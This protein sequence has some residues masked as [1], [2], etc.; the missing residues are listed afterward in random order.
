MINN[1]PCNISLKSKKNKYYKKGELV[2]ISWKKEKKWVFPWRWWPL[3]FM[4]IRLKIVQIHGR[5][6]RICVLVSSL[7]ILLW[8]FVLNKVCWSFFTCTCACVWNCF[9]F[10]FFA[11]DDLGVFLFLFWRWVLV[12]LSC[13]WVFYRGFLFNAYVGCIL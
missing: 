11:K 8:F 13:S 12:P 4:M 5:R 3:I 7:V 1:Q 9:W 2:Y 6:G 10:V